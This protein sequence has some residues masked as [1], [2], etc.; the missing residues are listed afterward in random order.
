MN[1]KRESLFMNH[2]RL[3]FAAVMAATMTVS[4]QALGQKEKKPSNW[5][6][7]TAK[8]KTE[9]VQQEAKPSPVPWLV[10]C[11][12]TGTAVNCVASQKLFLQ[13]TKQLLLGVTIR[14][15]EDSKTGVMMIQLPH[16][17][18]IPDGVQL[19]VDKAKPAQHSV[20]T[21]NQQGCYVGFSIDAPLLKQMRSGNIMSVSFKNLNKKEV[22]IG[23]PLKGFDKAF[24]KIKS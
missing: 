21:C 13:K 4:F 23:V 1:S 11:A 19:K 12:S 5:S 7:T 17:I 24:D 16:G 22:K 3:L 15:P 9:A 2:N 14:R 20:Q 10:N 8:T 6:A 18:H